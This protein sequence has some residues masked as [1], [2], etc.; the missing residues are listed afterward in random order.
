M[1]GQLAR[2]HG[3]PANWVV[4]SPDAGTTVE[5]TVQR[6]ALGLGP[7]VRCR[8]TREAGMLQSRDLSSPCM[9]CSTPAAVKASSN[10][11]TYRGASTVGAPRARAVHQEYQPLAPLMVS[12]ASEARAVVGKLGAGRRVGNAG[13]PSRRGRPPQMLYRLPPEETN[14]IS[15]GCSMPPCRRIRSSTPRAHPVVPVECRPVG[16]IGTG[17][18]SSL[19]TI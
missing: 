18:P 2:M 8:C 14:L 9:A 17:R 15:Q 13:M 19:S 1:P 4:T 3:A 6:R 5:H 10:A 12:N 7:V 11:R 16:A